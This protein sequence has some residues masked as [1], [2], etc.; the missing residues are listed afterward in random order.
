MKI[1]IR[2]V[3]ALAIGYVVYRLFDALIH[4]ASNS[5]VLGE[6]YS[7]EDV[8]LMAQ[9]DPEM[10][11]IVLDQSALLRDIGSDLH[12]QRGKVCANLKNLDATYAEATKM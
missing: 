11:G 9:H 3:S 2:A 7:V 1:G 12:N 10:L 6:L 4:V 5:D 8:Q